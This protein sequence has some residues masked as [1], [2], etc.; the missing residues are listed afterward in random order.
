MVACGAADMWAVG[1]I[2]YQL[3][4]GK[5]LGCVRC[6]ERCR[7]GVT[8]HWCGDRAMVA[9]GGSRHVGSGGDRLPAGNRCGYSSHNCDLQLGLSGV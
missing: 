2:A 3:A 4:T 5:V 9:C 8:G 6:C 7:V 1:V